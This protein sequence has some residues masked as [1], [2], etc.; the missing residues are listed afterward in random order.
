MK[1]R[2]VCSSFNILYGSGGQTFQDMVMK[3]LREKFSFGNK[4]NAHFNYVGMQV[5][6]KNEDITVSQDHYVSMV[7]V[8]SFEIPKEIVI[9]ELEEVS[10]ELFR[11]I[12]GMIGWVAN[13]SRPDLNFNNVLLSTKLGINRNEVY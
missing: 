8:P 10:Q 7:E 1:Y 3:P 6:Q 5:A 11:S 4:E 9:G 2:S 13:H 12:I